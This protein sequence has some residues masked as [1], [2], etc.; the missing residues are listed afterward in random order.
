MKLLCVV[1]SYWPAF[2]YGGPVTSVHA[3][4]KAM[5]AQGVD[6]SVYTT[7]AGLNGQ[8]PINRA[9][10]VDGV[11]VTYFS[12]SPYL[13]FLGATGWQFS[14]R[15]TE[16][17]RTNINR[18]DLVYIVS[19]WNYP[20]IMAAHYC[21]EYGKPYIVSPRG[22]LYP[23]TVNKKG[24]KKWPYYYLAAKK[25]LESAAA[26]HYTTADEAEKTHPYL[27][28]KQRF[29]VIPNGIDLREFQ[30]IPAK[31]EL[32]RLYPQ[33]NG[34]KVILFLGRISWKKGLDIVVATYRK[35]IRE[36]NDLHL[37]IAGHD[38]EGFGAQVK[39]L[40]EQS[41]I[42]YTDE[43]GA[44]AH[45]PAVTFTG[46]LIGREKLAAY[47]GSDLLILPSYSENFGMTVLEAMACGTAVVISDGVGI[48]REVEK[49][50]A[51][52]VIERR[53]DKLYAG[54]RYLLAHPDSRQELVANGKQMAAAYRC[55]TIAQ[56]M[57]FELE[58]LVPAQA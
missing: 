22:H 30:E 29:L 49:Y 55:E 40:L 57:I 54:I 20:S 5:A 41:G 39:S 16:C 51:G 24:W 28:L 13:E 3:L 46:M 27:G 58:K 6:I 53:T 21:R 8:V 32:C 18:F 2:Q 37:L 14:W 9:T 38:H 31:Q 52:L 44:P 45:N 50:R 11:S 25:P 23:E 4:N 17:L 48:A 10:E 42:P 35:L 56:N 12:F 34:K 19:I 43:L 1:P 47:A 36:R 26:I 33:L 15:M 7:N